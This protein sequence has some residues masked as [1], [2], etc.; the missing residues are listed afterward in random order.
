M[1]PPPRAQP[2]SPLPLP[3]L[4]SADGPPPGGVHA[5]WRQGCGG[6]PARLQGGGG[7]LV[8]RR[9][10]THGRQPRRV[11][12]AKPP[13]PPPAGSWVSGM[14]T[15]IIAIHAALLKV[16]LRCSCAR[17]PAEQQPVVHPCSC[18]HPGAAP[19]APLHPRAAPQDGNIAVW[20][21]QSKNGDPTSALIDPTGKKGWQPLVAGCGFY[22]CKNAFCGG[23]PWVVAG[24]GHGLHRLAHTPESGRLAQQRRTR[25]AQP[26]PFPSNHAC[27]PSRHTH[28]RN[29]H[30]R[31]GRMHVD[32]GRL[33]LLA[34]SLP[35]CGRCNV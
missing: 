32:G 17:G 1:M 30:R 26:K 34:V 25:H 8:G 6:G 18:P 24:S 33:R 23:A 9:L 13:P 7:A 21:P 2:P 10:S 19:C 11:L 22:A 31:C 27:S 20:T 35:R 29:H 15:G 5:Q 4:P 3:C 14:N 28:E 16:R 12:P